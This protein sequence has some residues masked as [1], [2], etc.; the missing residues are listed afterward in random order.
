[1]TSFY[2][3]NKI[4]FNSVK[5]GDVMAA[6]FENLWYRIK[7][8]IVVKIMQFNLLQPYKIRVLEKFP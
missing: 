1:M 8:L 7:V 5:R 2:S 6:A 3:K 4:D